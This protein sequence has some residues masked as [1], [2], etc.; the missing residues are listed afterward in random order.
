[1]AKNEETETKDYSDEKQ[2]L[3]IDVL[4]SSEEIFARC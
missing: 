4:L 1:M 2:K 3:L